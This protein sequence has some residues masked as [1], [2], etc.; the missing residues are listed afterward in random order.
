M[1][2]SILTNNG[3]MTALQSLKSTQKSLLNAQNRISTGL[4]VSTAKDNAA[5]WAVATAMR[6]DIANTKQVSENLSVSSSIIGTA[7]TAAEQIAD[8]V[9]QIRTKVT[10]AQ[11]PAVD[12]AQV[13]AD[14]DG[15][16]ETI[17]SIVS[18]AS[19]KGVNLVNGSGT[20]KVLTSVNSVDGV[21]TAAYA[22]VA[23][24]NLNVSADGL[25]SGLKD[26]TVL[27]RADQTFA[28][29]NDGTQ[30]LEISVDAGLS[31]KAGNIMKF[32]YVD[33]T[34]SDRTLEVKVT[35]DITDV[36]TL[37]NYLNA[38][39]TF[40]KM[41]QAD[42]VYTSGTT[43]DADTLTIS[44][45][46][47]DVVQSLGTIDEATKAVTYTNVVTLDATSGAGGLLKSADPV[48]PPP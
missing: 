39:A 2:S 21:S 30:K 42:R 28:K 12:K 26:L 4:K 18:A 16:I 5:T 41:F 11:N 47:R 43:L 34:N 37:T 33:Q 14:I 10:S 17:K 36:Q 44:A 22:D 9:K 38:D 15:Y 32:K 40:S 27:S 35:K 46:N 31:L 19:F 1:V 48:G 29:A 3:A 8:A 6:S 23:K 20:Q 13:Q 45:K 7:E 25:L 24:Q